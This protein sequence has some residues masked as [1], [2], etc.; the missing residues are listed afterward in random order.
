MSIILVIVLDVF[1]KNEKAYPPKKGP[2]VKENSNGNTSS[3]YISQAQGFATVVEVSAEPND[4]DEPEPFS[5]SC[6]PD[7]PDVAVEE[8]CFE[9]VRREGSVEVLVDHEKA[10]GSLG[11]EDGSSDEEASSKR[12]LEEEEEI[13][14]AREDDKE[15]N[16]EHGDMEDNTTAIK[17]AKQRR[18]NK[19]NQ[20]EAEDE[21]DEEEGG[22]DEYEDEGSANEDEEGSADEDEEG[23]ADEDADEGS[24]DA[25]EEEGSDDGDFSDSDDGSHYSPPGSPGSESDGSLSPKRVTTTAKKQKQE[26]GK[27]ATVKKRDLLTSEE[28]EEEVAP[29]KDTKNTKG[30]QPPTRRRKNSLDNEVDSLKTELKRQKGQFASRFKKIEMENKSLRKKLLEAQEI[31]K[32]QSK[33]IKEL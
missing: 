2:A 25:D 15:K 9:D 8:E 7:V 19:E 20:E 5:E 11:T 18:N 3:V 31:G 14:E 17:V 27:R 32:Q 24:A 29:Q 22:E 4:M 13:V 10:K 6:L 1:Q 26:V 12:V 30:N 16:M 33:R 28:D 21:D 23:S